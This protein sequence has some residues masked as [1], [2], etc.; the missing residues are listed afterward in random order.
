MFS[1]TQVEPWPVVLQLTC[2]TV[3]LPR[4]GK[5]SHFL[6]SGW[7]SAMYM[8]SAMTQPGLVTPTGQRDIP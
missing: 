1:A 4:A 2:Y 7:Y 6:Y 8:Y 5:V 3:P